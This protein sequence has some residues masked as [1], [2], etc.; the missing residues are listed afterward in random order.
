MVNK[1]MIPPSHLLTA[2]RKLSP[3]R[4]VK[5]RRQFKRGDYFISC[6]VAR[7]QQ[8]GQEAT[9]NNER[10]VKNMI[11]MIR[12]S[13][14][15]CLRSTSTQHNRSLMTPHETDKVEH[16]FRTRRTSQ[17]PFSRGNARQRD[18]VTIIRTLPDTQGFGESLVLPRA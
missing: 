14:N 12:V 6:S 1:L 18:I 17:N 11:R 15:A 16:Q 13:I 4:D 3:R 8:T 2:P 7:A 5:P 10:P 9:R